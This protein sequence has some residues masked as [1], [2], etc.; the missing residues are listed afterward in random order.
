MSEVPMFLF[1]IWLQVCKM[2]GLCVV[3]SFTVEL[4]KWLLSSVSPAL[5][6][7]AQGISLVLMF[8]CLLML[9]LTLSAF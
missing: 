8:S 4:V 3:F 7:I 9:L 5:S 1:V 2:D 6:V